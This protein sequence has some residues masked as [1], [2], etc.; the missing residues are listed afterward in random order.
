MQVLTLS[1]RRSNFSHLSLPPTRRTALV[2]APDSSCL[3]I[4][5]MGLLQDEEDADL[6]LGEAG[7]GADDGGDEDSSDEEEGEEEG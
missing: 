5:D 4:T 1:S 6:D 7:D 2:G 3:K